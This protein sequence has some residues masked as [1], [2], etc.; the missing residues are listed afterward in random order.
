MDS[1]GASGAGAG[2]GEVGPR[3]AF[4]SLSTSVGM[5]DPKRAIH[6]LVG[7]LA[8]TLQEHKEPIQLVLVEHDAN[9]RDAFAKVWTMRHV[10]RRVS[11]PRLPNLVMRCC[12]GMVR[13]G[14]A[15][16]CIA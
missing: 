14:P 3:L 2:E 5:Y 10:G 9:L 6:V 1:S 11:W 4:T 12:A 13:P 15:R 7:V 16:G 8:E